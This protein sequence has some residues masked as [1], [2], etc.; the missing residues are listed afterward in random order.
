MRVLTGKAATASRVRVLIES[1]DGEM[2]WTT[3]GVNTD[4]IAAS[5][6]ALADSIEYYLHLKEGTAK[7]Q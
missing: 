5:W 2:D 4:I 1:S 3:T 7:C 6:E